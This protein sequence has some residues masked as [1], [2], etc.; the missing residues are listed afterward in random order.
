MNFKPGDKVWVHHAGDHGLPR[1]TYAGVLI[2][3]KTPDMCL[4]DPDAHLWWK[5]DMDDYPPGP[6]SEGTYAHESILTP[7]SDPPPQQEP[8]QQREP[9]WDD[10]E[11]LVRWRP[12][13]TEVV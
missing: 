11:R 3:N 1:G 7:R 2:A 5:V 10:I 8:K 6:N 12:A 9:T 13:A 4:G